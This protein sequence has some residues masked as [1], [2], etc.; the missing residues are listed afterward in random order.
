MWRED[1]TWSY[2]DASCEEEER[3]VKFYKGVQ[4]FLP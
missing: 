4:A 3:S 1:W 2:S